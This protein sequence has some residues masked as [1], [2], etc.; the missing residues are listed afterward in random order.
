MRKQKHL[1]AE[2]HS[3]VEPGPT[4]DAAGGSRFDNDLDRH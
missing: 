2:F 4:P 3:L 1:L